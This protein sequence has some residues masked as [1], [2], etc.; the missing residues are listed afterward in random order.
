MKVL[1]VIL[2][3]RVKGQRRLAC[4]ISLNLFSL[5]RLALA[6]IVV[7]TLLLFDVIVVPGIVM[8]WVPVMIEGALIDNDFDSGVTDRAAEV[9]VRLDVHLDFFAKPERLLFAILFRRF[10]GHFEFRQFVFFQPK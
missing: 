10:H 8:A 3:R 9:I 6:A 7:T 1:I 2:S 5:Y 4:G